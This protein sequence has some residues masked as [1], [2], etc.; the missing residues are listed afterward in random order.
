MASF[1]R[2]ANYN[3]LDRG[4]ENTQIKGA[5]FCPNAYFHYYK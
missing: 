3:I 5:R 2:A 4:D 1:Q